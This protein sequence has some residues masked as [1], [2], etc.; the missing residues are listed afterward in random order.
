MTSPASDP[1]LVG[2]HLDPARDGAHVENGADS[3]L[4]A[5]CA[6][7]ERTQLR[8]LAVLRARTSNVSAANGDPS[9]ARR[10]VETLSFYHVDAVVQ[11]VDE[12]ERDE[13]AMYHDGWRLQFC[14]AKTVTVALLCGDVL[15]F[16]LPAAA[17]IARGT[18]A[19]AQ[20]DALGKGLLKSHRAHHDKIDALRLAIKRRKVDGNDEDVA[21][22]DFICS[23]ASRAKYSESL[24]AAPPITIS[25]GAP[26]G[27]SRAAPQLL[28]RSAPQPTMPPR[29]P[30]AESMPVDQYE[31]TIALTLELSRAEARVKA[32]E[33]ACS[34]WKAEA[35]KSAA[36][37]R[38]AEADL[39]NLRAE[40][41]HEAAAAKKAAR[42]DVKDLKLANLRRSELYETD[43]KLALAENRRLTMALKLANDEKRK[44]AA[45]LAKAKPIAE[46]V[47]KAEADAKEATRTIKQLASSLAAAELLLA[48]QSASRLAAQAARAA[49]AVSEAAANRLVRQQ[50]RQLDSKASEL[51]RERSA[52]QRA[53]SQAAE[54]AQRAATLE[55]RLDAI[56]ALRGKGAQEQIKTLAATAAKLEAR[57]VQQEAA[58]RKARADA[59][60]AARQARL[61]MKSKSASAVDAAL[62]KKRRTEDERGGA[63]QM[64]NVEAIMAPLVEEARAAAAAAKAELAGAQREWAAEQAESARE[65]ARLKAIAE[66]TLQDMK[67]NRARARA[68][69][70]RPRPPTHAAQPARRRPL[71]PFVAQARATRWG[72][73]C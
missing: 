68:P 67:K 20:Y 14:F 70:A 41:E 66:P 63:S 62:H 39:R 30:R 24:R 12:A 48:N 1:S 55:A 25:A 26:S 17:D 40:S 38:A 7:L 9:L 21:G 59:V 8:A 33:E 53:S 57:L 69:A 27:P 34:A 58:A 2:G 37:A 3:L 42:A 56:K 28:T 65:I 54:L 29:R 16:D 71:R 23:S 11:T 35:G 47:V 49:S 43:A 73:R 72:S 46:R 52:A 22:I 32:T 4:E 45:D 50:S 5:G 13:H 36:D 18:F 44:L 60:E 51:E 10:N 19:Y 15:G 31:T 61:A 6:E 64:I